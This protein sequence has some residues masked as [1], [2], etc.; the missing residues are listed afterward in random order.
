M[1]KFVIS[2]KDLK[3]NINAIKKHAKTNGKDDNGNEVK[4][5][6]VVKSNGYGL[7]LIEYVNF[8]IDNRYNKFCSSYC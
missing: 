7:G 3:H 6:A 1:N 2:K 4:I 5:I 8:L